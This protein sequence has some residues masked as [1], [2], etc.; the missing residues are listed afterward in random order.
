MKSNDTRSYCLLLMPSFTS[1]LVKHVLS[2]QLLEHFYSHDL[3]NLNQFAY[4]IDHSIDTAFLSIKMFTYH[5]QELN[6]L[7][8]YSLGSQLLLI[9]FCSFQLSSDMVQAWGSVLTWFTSHL[10][11][12]YKSIKIGST[13]SDC[14]KFLFGVL[15]G[16][17]LG[18]LPPL[19]FNSPISE[20]KA[21][22]MK[23]KTGSPI[24]SNLDWVCTVY[25]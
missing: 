12:H 9:P 25:F 14:C 23:L 15:Q 21:P 6:L 8:W 13:L 22:Y 4:K 18:P 20:V 24:N 11:E 5:C 1:K 10:S 2:M 7:P 17:I 3:Q 19:S 16:S